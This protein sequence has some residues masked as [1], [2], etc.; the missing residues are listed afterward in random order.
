M[1][2]GK[3]KEDQTLKCLICESHSQLKLLEYVHHVSA[4][5]KEV[6]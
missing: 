1:M 4:Q 2:E 3:R 6:G 5:R